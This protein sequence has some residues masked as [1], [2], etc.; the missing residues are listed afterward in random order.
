METTVTLDRQLDMDSIDKLVES[1]ECIKD[2]TTS[3]GASGAQVTQ[4][5][6]E[7]GPPAI[8]LVT[9]LINLYGATLIIK[10]AKKSDDK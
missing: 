5:M 9:A 7:F 4:L 10:S 3:V 6:V 2:D 8:E 1:Y